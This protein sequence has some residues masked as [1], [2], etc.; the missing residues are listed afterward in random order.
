MNAQKGVEILGE[1]AGSESDGVVGQLPMGVGR[2]GVC[3]R[4]DR[5]NSF[6]EQVLSYTS[7]HQLF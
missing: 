7:S 2:M 6:N 4:C 1:A 3:E 5:V